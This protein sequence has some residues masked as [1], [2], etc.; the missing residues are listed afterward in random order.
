[1][2]RNDVVKPRVEIRFSVDGFVVAKLRYKRE[3]DLAATRSEKRQ[4]AL[5]DAIH[6]NIGLR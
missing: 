3:L 1:M 5:H 6:D 4:I 2:S